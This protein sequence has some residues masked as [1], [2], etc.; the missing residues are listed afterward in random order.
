M[1]LASLELWEM[2]E[3]LELELEL[4]RIVAWKWEE[5][6]LLEVSQMGWQH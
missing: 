1:D 2:V 6:L 5:E 4:E 3:A